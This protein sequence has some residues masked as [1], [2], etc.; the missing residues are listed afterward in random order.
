MYPYQLKLV[1]VR[2]CTPHFHHFSIVSD[3]SVNA[4]IVTNRMIST[5]SAP[6]FHLQNFIPLNVLKRLLNSAYFQ[7]YIIPLAKSFS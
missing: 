4:L 6:T 3:F 7:N 1:Y 2:P 5:T